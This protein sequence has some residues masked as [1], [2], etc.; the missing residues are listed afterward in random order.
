MRRG[1]P[2]SIMRNHRHS[3][4]FN[5]N[6]KRKKIINYSEEATRFQDYKFMARL[7]THGSNSSKAKRRHTL[8][9]RSISKTAK[10]ILQYQVISSLTAANTP[11]EKRKQPFPYHANYARSTTSNVSTFP[12]MASCDGKEYNNEDKSGTRTKSFISINQS[13]CLIQR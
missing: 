3:S 10:Q 1:K 6:C 7:T 13:R 11:L 4:T 12:T 2:S 8:V 5:K 9:C